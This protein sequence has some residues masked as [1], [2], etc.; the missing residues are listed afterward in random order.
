MCVC[1]HAWRACVRACV[2]AH[3]CACVFPFGG[4]F[5]NVMLTMAEGVPPGKVMKKRR[6]RDLKV[7]GLP[8][9]CCSFI[10]RAREF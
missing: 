2:C 4:T 7:D 9:P 8:L 1:V 6:E 10:Q 3:V 5:T